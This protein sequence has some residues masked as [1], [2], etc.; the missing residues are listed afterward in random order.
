M[1]SSDCSAVYTLLKPFDEHLK[2][3]NVTEV[4]MNKYGE[5]WCNTFDGWES[6]DVP[7]LTESYMASVIRSIATF[8][9]IAISPHM[10]VVLPDGERGSIATYPAVSEGSISFVIRKHSPTVKSLH[11]IYSDGA[12][13][14]L[15]D[16]SFNIPDDDQIEAHSTSGDT[17]QLTK[18]ESHLLRLKNQNNYVEFLKEA[19]LLKRNII[20]AGK[21]GSGK[22]TLARSLIEEVPLSERIITIE[23]VPELILPNHPN[24]VN[25]LFGDINGRLSA[26]ECL[27]ACM[28]QSPDRIFLAEIRG[29]E[30]WDYINSLNTG[31][32][33]SISTVHA[34]NA[35]QSFDRITSLIKQSETGQTLH[36]QFIKDF[37][38]NTID[39]VL[40]LHKRRVLEVFYDPIFSKSHSSS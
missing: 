8:N 11:D 17:T 32:P 20:I 25:M 12:F 13:D 5:V 36:V 31:H 7:E 29:N 15:V 4:L 37:L 40:F 38:Y 1:N 19:V 3:S 23:D 10:D 18:N 2:K 35:I 28:R 22:T 39:I 27:R 21:T 30:S 14:D 9:H 16:V 24:Q 34:N 33:G 6:F 26:M